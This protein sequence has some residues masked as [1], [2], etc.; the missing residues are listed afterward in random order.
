MALLGLVVS[1]LV[2]STPA[3]AQ[4]KGQ[5]RGA[6]AEDEQ[7]FCSDVKGAKVRTQCLKDREAE[8]SQGW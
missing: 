4:E 1:S 6:C 2:W 3:L 5:Q 8:L 7:K